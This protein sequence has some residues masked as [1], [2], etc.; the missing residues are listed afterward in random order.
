MV[1][2]FSLTHAHSHTHNNNVSYIFTNPSHPPI[3]TTISHLPT[4][5]KP[6]KKSKKSKKSKK[7]KK[8]SKKAIN[9]GALLQDYDASGEFYEDGQGNYD[10]AYEENG[11]NSD[12]Y[13][14]EGD[15]SFVAET[16][17]TSPTPAKKSWF[18]SS[19]SASAKKAPKAASQVEW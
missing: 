5:L 9:A 10:D 11:G 19:S 14:Y 17:T 1:S 4:D 16:T 18:R 8:L 2:F 7:N 6:K 15:A 12:A 13:D 3:P